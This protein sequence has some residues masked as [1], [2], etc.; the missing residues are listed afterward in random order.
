MRGATN[1]SKAGGA[2]NTIDPGATGQSTEQQQQHQQEP[3]NS[4]NNSGS[5]ATKYESEKQSP[6]NSAGSQT[7]I[8]VAGKGSDQLHPFRYT[9]DFILNLYKTMELPID[10]V[11]NDIATSPTI[12]PPIGLK[13][14][15]ED[16]LKLFKG[17]VNSNLTKRFIMQQ[18]QQ[19]QHMQQQARHQVS[20]GSWTRGGRSKNYTN[21][22]ASGGGNN[23]NNR[24][25]HVGIRHKQQQDGGSVKDERRKPT[26]AAE[27]GLDDDRPNM[28]AG[29]NI[30]RNMVGSF[31]ADGV[32]RID[33]IDDKGLELESLE[34]GLPSNDLGSVITSGLDQPLQAQ[35]PLQQQ[36]SALENYLEGNL[37]DKSALLSQGE[38]VTSKQDNDGFLPSYI[39]GQRND[40][41]Q[42]TIA[43]A[44]MGQS[45]GQSSLNIRWW[46]RDAYE[47]IQGPFPTENMEDWYRNGYFPS[48]LDVKFGDRDFE[49]L[50]SLIYKVNDIKTPFTTF[51]NF[52]IMDPNFSSTENIGLGDASISSSTADLPVTGSERL[53]DLPHLDIWA[54]QQQEKAD[55]P[56]SGAQPNPISNNIQLSQS[57]ARE[58]TLRQSANI[59]AQDPN[60]AQQSL[61][62]LSILEFQ[63]QQ[64]TKFIELQQSIVLIQHTGQQKLMEITAAFRQEEQKLQL[65]GATQDMYIQLQQ[66]FQLF[67]SQERH[68]VDQEIQAHTSYLLQIEQ[69]FD[70]LVHDTIRQGGLEY[71]LNFI[72]EQI[73]VTRSQISADPQLLSGQQPMH[74]HGQ[75][76]N[77][78]NNVP[79]NTANQSEDSQGQQQQQQQQQ[80]PA[81]PEA[82]ASQAVESKS[83]PGFVNDDVK[84]LEK[85]LEDAKISEDKKESIDQSPNKPHIDAPVLEVKNVWNKPKVVYDK[86]DIANELSKQKD[87]PKSSGTQKDNTKDDSADSVK[88]AKSANQSQKKG[89]S[90]SAKIILSSTTT[91]K[92]EP[93][94]PTM[95]STPWGNKG[96]SSTPKKSLAEIQQEEE[97]RAHENRQS[98]QSN[99][100]ISTSASGLKEEPSGR[101]IYV[102][103]LNTESQSEKIV[104]QGGSVWNTPGGLTGGAAHTSSTSTNAAL[105]HSPLV[106]GGSSRNG[107]ERSPPSSVAVAPRT[108]GNTISSPPASFAA[109][110]SSSSRASSGNAKQK[111]GKSGSNGPHTPSLQF[112]TWCRAKLR[113]LHGINVDEFIQVLLSFPLN[114]PKSSLDIITEQV[115]AYSKDLNGRQFAEEFVKK[116]KED[117]AGTFS[118][119]IANSVA[120]NSGFGKSSSNDTPANAFQ[121]VGKKGRR[122]N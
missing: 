82:D 13:K 115:H 71:A 50:S 112:I 100:V 55:A 85:K 41:T 74:V 15:T 78:G 68:R 24:G 30:Q 36:Q 25:S 27:D 122:R 117:A 66:R 61:Q 105:A 18:Q 3:H 73:N 20:G 43:N 79:S 83:T 109:T 113:G 21:P 75:S 10:F 84:S 101:K 76:E 98:K 22:A 65:Q 70:P 88:G 87:I 58:N 107:S 97:A 32:F 120:I 9:R 95:P 28:W 92:I 77:I 40:L 11:K 35:P 45:M 57:N 72:R 106:R 8:G 47:N 80:Q 2:G 56:T 49:P 52:T 38:P 104:S 59:Q 103:L 110:A 99:H 64:I 51:V 5:A 19:Q 102:Q 90:K 54:S 116:R 29:M 12:N 119:N 114:P 69:T 6:P 46:Y 118:S 39:T 4:G 111:P 23:L 16:E 53:S 94:S 37:V 48:N 60:K 63:H 96:A 42:E 93:P 89:N 34:S 86:D 14:M 91:T 108:I 26:T 67:E 33:G 7:Y 62:I 17:P 121:V 1:A 81:K 44:T 31:G